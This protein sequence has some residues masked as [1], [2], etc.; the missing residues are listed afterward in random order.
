ME[1]T[2]EQQIKLLVEQNDKLNELLTEQSQDEKKE[3][4][5]QVIELNN[6]IQHSFASQRNLDE[7]KAEL[8][9]EIEI[10]SE[11]ELRNK[12]LI[13]VL[14]GSVSGAIGG[15]SGGAIIGAILG[16]SIAPAI[17]TITG[18]ILGAVAPSFTKGALKKISGK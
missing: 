15:V 5:R 10:L 18:F 2:N 11:K 12:Q 1:N 13:E 8:E 17:G 14:F 9:K 3:M 7:T 6:R 4:L 16:S